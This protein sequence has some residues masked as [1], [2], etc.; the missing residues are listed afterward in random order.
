MNNKRA[1]QIFGNRGHD[2]V[3]RRL[4]SSWPWL[5]RDRMSKQKTGRH[6]P[7]QILSAPVLIT[8]LFTVSIFTQ[9]IIDYNPANFSYLLSYLTLGLIL[10]SVLLTLNHIIILALIDIGGVLILPGILPEITFFEVIPPFVF[11]SLSIGLVLL[12]VNQRNKSRINRKADSRKGE[13]DFGANS[14]G[15]NQTER[16]LQASEANLRATLNSIGDAVISTDI[17]GKIA[18]MNPVAEQLTGWNLAEAQGK[19]LTKVFKIVNSQT[20]KPA[21]NPVGKVLESG[22]FVGLANHTMLI[23]K[24]GAEYQIADSAAPIINE[25]GATT[26]VVLV[27]RDVTEEYRMQEALRESEARFQQLAEVVDEVFVISDVKSGDVIYANPAFE[28]IWGQ[29]IQ[30]LYEDVGVWDKGIHQDDRPRIQEAW[31]R[32]VEQGGLFDEEYRVIHSDESMRWIRGRA[33][34]IRDESGE[35]YRVAELALNITNRKQIEAERAALVEN[36][37]H[38]SLLVQTAVNVSKSAIAILSPEELVQQ[39]VDL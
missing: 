29:P 25:T 16:A 11:L 1:L 3:A 33:Y 19:A 17:Q 31:A 24:D 28:K 9:I 20:K 10:P 13:S 14:E 18:N 21:V 2:G 34:P 32:T 37:E 8:S 38:R 27:F 6:L 26:G 35:I 15:P 30:K 39:A 4:T 5:T 12:T 23:A 36:L 7:G 22:K